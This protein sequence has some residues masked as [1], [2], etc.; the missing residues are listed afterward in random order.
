MDR[1][2]EFKELCDLAV[3][4]H[5]VEEIESALVHIRNVN[6]C[7]EL[8]KSPLFYCSTQN[9]SIEVLRVLIK[10]G[11]IITFTTL[12]D[13]IIHNTN[14]LVAKYLFSL[15]QPMSQQKLNSLFS[16]IFQNVVQ[17]CRQ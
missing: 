13:S 8:S 11:A 9:S 7:D 4:S 12:C 1:S 17:G 14:P 2:C 16:D 10:A 5:S 15:L 6:E 3:H